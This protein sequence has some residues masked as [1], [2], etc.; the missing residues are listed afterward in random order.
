MGERE[1]ERIT[2]PDNTFRFSYSPAIGFSL[3]F[4]SGPE[5]TK[6]LE[7]GWW[8]QRWEMI[9]GQRQFLFGPEKDLAFS[10]KD[11]ALATKAELEKAVD[12]ITEVAE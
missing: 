1:L 10:S 4:V 3:K 6:D 12:I 11:A 2:V 7:A 8:L 5:L 9:G